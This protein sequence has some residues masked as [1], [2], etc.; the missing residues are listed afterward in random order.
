VVSRRAGIGIPIAMAVAAGGL[1]A[2]VGIAAGGAAARGD[3]IL[4]FAVE[5]VL[6][7]IERMLADAGVMGSGGGT[8]SALLPIYGTAADIATGAP[9]PTAAA[10]AAIEFGRPM[11]GLLVVIAVTI[12]GALFRAAMQRGRDWCYPGA[13]AGCVVMIIV[14]SFVDVTFF[15]TAVMLV[16]SVVVGL[17]LAQSASR[18]VR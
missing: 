6:P 13:A 4:R 12:A 16:A 10:T 2:A 1:V 15:A 8:F 11:W 17:G 7:A 3:P 18:A 5:E 14:E 9:A